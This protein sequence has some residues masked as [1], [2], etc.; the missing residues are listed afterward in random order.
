MRDYLKT[1][2]QA[3]QQ[4]DMKSMMEHTFILLQSTIGP[5][6]HLMAC[7]YDVRIVFGKISLVSQ[8]LT[9]T[10]TYYW[11]VARFFRYY[12]RVI[13]YIQIIDTMYGTNY[14]DKLKEVWKTIKTN[15]TKQ[16]L[17]P[18][19]LQPFEEILN[20]IMAPILMK[21]TFILDDL[22]KQT[23]RCY[24]IQGMKDLLPLIMESNAFTNYLR[25]NRFDFIDNP[26]HIFNECFAF[27]QTTSETLDEK[28]LFIVKK[29]LKQLS[30]SISRI[31][32]LFDTQTT[33]VN[34]LTE[35]TID[36]L[37]QND[38][39]NASIKLSEL[40]RY[41][42]LFPRM[43]LLVNSFYDKF[44]DPSITHVEMTTLFNYLREIKLPKH[45]Q[46]L[47]LATHGK[48][49]RSSSDPLLI[50]PSKMSKL[51]EKHRKTNTPFPQKQQ[52]N[53]SIN[54]IIHQLFQFQQSFQALCDSHL[55][56]GGYFVQ[57]ILNLLHYA[58]TIP[59]TIDDIDDYFEAIARVHNLILP[60][61][62]IADSSRLSLFKY[63]GFNG[64][65]FKT[66]IH[67]LRE[68]MIFRLK[69]MSDQ[70]SPQIIDEM[71]SYLIG[72]CK[73][74]L[75]GFWFHLDIVGYLHQK[76]ICSTDS[77]S[78]DAHI[79]IH[80]VAVKIILSISGNDISRAVFDILNENPQKKTELPVRY[81]RDVQRILF[82]VNNTQ[83]HRRTTDISTAYMMG[84]PSLKSI[85]NS[86]SVLISL[87]VQTSPNEETLSIIHNY[88][89]DAFKGM[90]G[91][92]EIDEKRMDKL[93]N[94]IQ[95][96]F[97]QLHN[98]VYTIN[99][100]HNEIVET[101]SCLI[102]N[103][104]SWRILKDPIE[105]IMANQMLMTQIQ[106]LLEL[107][108]E[109][110]FI[111]NNKLEV[112]KTLKMIEETMKIFDQSAFTFND[113]TTLHQKIFMTISSLFLHIVNNQF[114]IS[115]NANELLH[116]LQLLSTE[117]D[118]KKLTHHAIMFSKKLLLHSSVL[119][120]EFVS[121][122][123]PIMKLAEERITASLIISIS[124]SQNIQ[125]LPMYNEHTRKSNRF[126][127]VINK[128]VENSL[129]FYKLKQLRKK[130]N[131]NDLPQSFNPLKLPYFRTNF[132]ISKYI[133]EISVAFGKG[134]TKQLFSIVRRL[135]ENHKSLTISF[136]EINSVRNDSLKLEKCIR[137]VEAM[138]MLNRLICWMLMVCHNY[139]TTDDIPL[140]SIQFEY[141]MDCC[142]RISALNN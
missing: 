43:Y 19:D 139:V 12:D 22:F 29:Y 121:E 114:D 136:E 138:V 120:C 70:M 131:V 47:Q 98:S 35:K 37:S 33:L 79:T 101:M 3:I 51:K 100:I 36:Y 64:V 58:E 108:A 130:F 141:F 90:K 123:N 49:E 71:K 24:L 95:L 38:I 46:S 69:E 75:K 99:D 77:I 62:W 42:R 87:M 119:I 28:S 41:F 23:N 93:R 86:I 102:Y 127:I 13:G 72:I 83:T 89:R 52:S 53:I 122:T 55:R 125:I 107:L 57:F 39:V 103:C 85:R 105:Y 54:E 124:L 30:E 78:G 82:T 129:M 91:S 113:Y 63:Y 134:D 106:F 45:Q 1:F 4:N 66:I 48:I 110:P 14:G 6:Y 74:L 115:R 31:F 73:E 32:R 7:Y 2:T 104:F 111:K 81:V 96:I 61:Y 40:K 59:N 44:N 20:K 140:I 112:I 34:E 109:L 137:R 116:L 9:H 56:Q 10:Y 27:I 8:R 17:H 16:K 135:I 94:L 80:P 128:I 142:E 25:D 92:K 88:Y 5:I 76:I 67:Q 26:L 15:V 126:M 117:S 132:K 133:T 97:S 68:E 84:T 60:L 21:I 65:F 118:V 18:T 50:I 11:I